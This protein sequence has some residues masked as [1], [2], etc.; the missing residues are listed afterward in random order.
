MGFF[1]GKS[2]GQRRNHTV[3]RLR[4]P[5]LSAAQK[6]APG[7]FSIAARSSGAK[8]PFILGE[9]TYGLKPVPFKSNANWLT[10]QRLRLLYLALIFIVRSGRVIF[11]KTGW[12][13]ALQ[14]SVSAKSKRRVEG[15]GSCC[16]YFAMRLPCSPTMFSKECVLPHFRHGPFPYVEEPLI[17]VPVL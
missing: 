12:S 13:A 17:H 7:L 11:C 2:N 10:V 16:S 9:S 14:F 3:L 4:Y 8:A 15:P 1:P 6:S 5:A